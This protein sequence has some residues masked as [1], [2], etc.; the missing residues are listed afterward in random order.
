[1]FAL[2]LPSRQPH[3]QKLMPFTVQSL[4][5]FLL[6]FAL[7]LLGFTAIKSKAANQVPIS[8]LSFSSFSEMRTFAS[9]SPFRTEKVSQRSEHLA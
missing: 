1:M 6:F 8:W 4:F 5:V 2:L 3:T 7:T 9:N